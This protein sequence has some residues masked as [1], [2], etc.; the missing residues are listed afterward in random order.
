MM[1]L[2]FSFISMSRGYY[3]FPATSLNLLENKTCYICFI[4]KTSLRQEKGFPACSCRTWTIDPPRFLSND[5][6][7]LFSASSCGGWAGF[8]TY[9]PM[10]ASHRLSQMRWLQDLSLPTKPQ[11]P[12]DHL[13]QSA[14]LH[15]HKARSQVQRPKSKVKTSPLFEFTPTI[16]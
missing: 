9:L 8:P 13:N 12:A 5:H 7:V 6:H 4:E 3:L 2:S 16:F 11:D 1:I 14:H 10:V 15:G